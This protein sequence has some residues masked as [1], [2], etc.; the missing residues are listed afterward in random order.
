MASAKYKNLFDGRYAVVT[1]TQIDPPFTA[2]PVAPEPLI[3]YQS[4]ELF[5]LKLEGRIPHYP[6]FLLA[7]CRS[8]DPEGCYVYVV[9]FDVLNNVPNVSKCDV[10]TSGKMP[11][12][13]QIYTKFSDTICLIQ[14]AA[15]T[16][17]MS[18]TAL[19][20][21]SKYVIGTDGL[22][23]IGGGAN[24]PVSTNQKQYIGVAITPKRLLCLPGLG[25]AVF[26]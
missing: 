22:P 20:P 7:T 12:I 13:G 3:K 16:E 11:G 4:V 10:T 2:D 17:W 8:T 25:D 26:A 19:V 14:I 15:G 24:Y 5:G 6:Q 1:P 21:G 9:D 18:G 23:A